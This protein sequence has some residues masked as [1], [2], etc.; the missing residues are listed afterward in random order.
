M[1]VL[2][3]IRVE[4]SNEFINIYIYQHNQ[5]TSHIFLSPRPK[6]TP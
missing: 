3:Y 5:A 6:L 2:P 4:G 1:E